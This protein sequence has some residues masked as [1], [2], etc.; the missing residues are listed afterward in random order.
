MNFFAWFYLV[1][2]SRYLSRFLRQLQPKEKAQ[3]LQLS[4]TC[5]Q[6]ANKEK[7]LLIDEWLAELKNVLGRP[8]LVLDLF[9]V[10]DRCMDGLVDVRLFTCELGVQ[11]EKSDNSDELVVKQP[12]I[13]HRRKAVTWSERDSKTLKE[14]VGTYGASNWSSV[15]VVLNEKLKK[16]QKK[17]FVARTAAQCCMYSF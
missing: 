14:V 9:L 7:T 2:M 13:N 11:D 3:L 5:V 4:L 15:A 12:I 16:Q 1:E 10:F 8:E 17:K 6:D